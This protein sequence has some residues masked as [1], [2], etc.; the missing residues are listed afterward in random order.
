V[1]ERGQVRK[2]VRSCRRQQEDELDGGDTPYSL[3]LTA[4]MAVPPGG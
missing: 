3:T 1:K 2:S 4:G